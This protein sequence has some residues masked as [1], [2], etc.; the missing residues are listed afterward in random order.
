MDKL[1]ELVKHLS[2]EK[3]EE[4]LFRGTSLDLGWGR[5]FGGQVLGQSISAAIQTVPQDRHI[6]SMHTYFLRQGD[7]H[8]PI[9]YAVTRLRDGGSFSARRIEAIQNGV[10][11]C[12][13]VASFAI[14]EDGF[15][16]ETPMPDAPLPESLPEEREVLAELLNQVPL[17]LES[18]TS[19]GAPIDLRYVNPLDSLKSPSRRKPHWMLWFK[20]SRS[21]PQEFPF[22]P[23]LL[24]YASDFGLLG[25]TILPHGVSWLTPGMQMASIDHTVWF[26]QEFRA[27][28]WLLHVM[29]SPCAHG[30]RGLARGCIYTREGRLVASTAQEGLIRFKSAAT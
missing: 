8:R 20:T 26:H 3:V 10:P 18:M 21:L 7:V 24:A 14:R 25:T 17:R 12:E 29:E 5:V 23:S 30:A 2:L 19:R 28:E 9:L 15:A 1:D 22:H 6:H 16:H 13:I 27:D 4:N 11:I